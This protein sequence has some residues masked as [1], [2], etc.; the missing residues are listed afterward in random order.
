VSVASGSPRVVYAAAVDRLAASVVCAL[1]G[2]HGVF[3]LCDQVVTGEELAGLAAVR[4]LGPDALAPVVL[5]GHR[6]SAED[7]EVVAASMRIFPVTTRDDQ[8]E[9]Q[10]EGGVPVRAL[11][12]WATGLVLTRLG[13]P[14]F[15]RSYPVSADVGPD[16]G[17]LPWVVLLAQLSP[18]AFPGVDSPVHAQVRRHRLDV[19]RGVTRAVLRRDY[20]TAARLVRWLAAADDPAGDAFFPLSAVMRHIELVTEPDARLLLE[21][22]VVRRSREVPGS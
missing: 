1:H 18:V 22:A 3:R 20:L 6:L 5:G 12:D 21:L 19:A 17:W 4:V 10:P 13:V 2:S 7:V 15:A 14:G 11:R 9:G 16:R 8:P